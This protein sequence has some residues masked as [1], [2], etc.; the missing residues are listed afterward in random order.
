MAAYVKAWREEEKKKMQNR[1]KL[2]RRAS[3]RYLFCWGLPELLIYG[4]ADLEL[5]LH[6]TQE[7]CAFLLTKISGDSRG[8][9]GEGFGA[10]G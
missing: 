10:Y 2:L 4:N 6:F 3:W 8:A 1:R 5:F 9:H 7:H